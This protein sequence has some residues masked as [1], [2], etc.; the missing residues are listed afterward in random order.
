MSV[1]S[2]S[3]T[4]L[5][6]DSVVRPPTA[7]NVKRTGGNSM[8]T[9]TIQGGSGFAGYAWTVFVGL[10]ALMFLNG[11]A[12]MFSAAAFSQNQ[13]NSLSELV[14]GVFGV[15][16]AVYGLRRGERWAWY[17]MLLWP[18][19]FFGLLGIHALW[20]VPVWAPSSLGLILG[21]M[22]FLGWP[23]FLILIVAALALSYR[24]VFSNHA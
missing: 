14:I 20:I 12:D 23:G 17:S 4:L 15:A 11:V 24:A 2:C 1:S 16:I 22:F 9:R 18:V 5:H 19:W 21:S 8:A 3:N 13:E 6:V 10:G 7:R